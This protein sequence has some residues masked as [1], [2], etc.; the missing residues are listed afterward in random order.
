MDWVW[1]DKMAY[2]LHSPTRGDVIVFNPPA[3]ATAGQP[4][5]DDS[6]WIKRLMAEGGDRFEVHAGF[7]MVD[8]QR[9]SHMDIRRA[10]A[11]NGYFGPGDPMSD[12]HEFMAVHHVK[13][14]P[15]G[16]LA[17]GRLLTT[18]QLGRVLTGDC[19]ALVV[20]SPGA[21]LRN[22]RV[23]TESYTAEDPDYDLKIWHGK[24][25]KENFG[26]GNRFELA[27]IPIDPPTYRA[28]SWHATGRIPRGCYFVMG[29]NRN[30]SDDST[31]WG[32]LPR[33]RIVGKAEAIFWPLGR[34]TCSL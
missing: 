1:V 13:F 20:V 5:T 7:V 24:P 29:D 34:M 31:E 19:N 15:N 26:E 22:G 17:D 14:I 25:L 21:V 2:R 8:G 32:C 4:S 27:G 3:N 33:G 18:S 9:F 23:L 12:I 28:L 6:P 16:A 30:D 10:L 11:L